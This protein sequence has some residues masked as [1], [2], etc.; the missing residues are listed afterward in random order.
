M[1]AAEGTED[2]LPLV[3]GEP[4]EFGAWLALGR[5]PRGPVKQAQLKGDARW[6]KKGVLVTIIDDQGLVLVGNDRPAEPALDGPLDPDSRRIIGLG[7]RRPHDP[8]G[9][10][11]AAFGLVRPPAA[12]PGPG[13]RQQ[14]P[15]PCR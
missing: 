6:I 11:A 10:A 9:P 1:A 3:P 12:W 15:G 4:G 5:Y 13:N 8:Y 14:W 7:G 2:D